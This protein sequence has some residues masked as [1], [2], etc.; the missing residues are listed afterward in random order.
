MRSARPN[1]FSINENE[2]LAQYAEYANW[3][4]VTYPVKPGV[5]RA[6]LTYLGVAL[7]LACVVG[8]GWLLR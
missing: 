2:R 6:M 5:S 8:L 3:Q 7:L 4:R 1:V